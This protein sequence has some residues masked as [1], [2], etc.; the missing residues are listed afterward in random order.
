MTLIVFLLILCYNSD[1]INYDTIKKGDIFKH[2]TERKISG[3]V[4]RIFR[5]I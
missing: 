3:F 5:N 2:G 4:G 1:K